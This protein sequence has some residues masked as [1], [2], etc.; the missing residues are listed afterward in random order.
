[1][2]GS[3]SRVQRRSDCGRWSICL[4]VSDLKSPLYAMILVGLRVEECHD[5]WCIRAC[6]QLVC[7]GGQIRRRKTQTPYHRPRSWWR[8]TT[9]RNWNIIS[10]TACWG[11][12][13]S[14]FGRDF[15]FLRSQD[16]WEIQDVQKTDHNWTRRVLPSYLGLRKKKDTVQGLIKKIRKR[17]GP[18]GGSNG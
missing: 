16:R 13:S 11:V 9:S 2:I 17:S 1:M 3:W 5:Y 8:I 10:S 4:A 18:K 15:G 6:R 14:P 7:L 12:G